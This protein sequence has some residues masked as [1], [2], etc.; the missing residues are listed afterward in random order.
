MQIYEVFNKEEEPL[1]D[2][3]ECSMLCQ[4]VVDNFFS[5]F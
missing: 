4:T 1:L 2:F 3:G 5:I